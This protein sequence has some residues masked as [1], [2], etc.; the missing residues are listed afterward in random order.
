MYFLI[1]LYHNYLYD[2]V[3]IVIIF[4]TLLSGSAT[5]STGRNLEPLFVT[6]PPRPQRLLHSEAYIRYYYLIIN[7]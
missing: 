3:Y 5:G 4:C 7:P 6:V 2:C 1:L